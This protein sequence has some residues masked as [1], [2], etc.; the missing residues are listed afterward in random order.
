MPTGRSGANTQRLAQ[1]AQY[2]LEQAGA[3]RDRVAEGEVEACLGPLG[4]WQPQLS[5]HRGGYGGLVEN[6]ALQH[7]R[8]AIYRLGRGGMHRASNQGVG[9]LAITEQA[10]A[11]GR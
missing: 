9:K 2:A 10:V 8:K 1:H 3:W 7:Q 4:E 6:A 5:P 11:T